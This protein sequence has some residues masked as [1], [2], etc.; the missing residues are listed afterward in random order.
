LLIGSI[1]D[2]A[3]SIVDPPSFRAIGNLTLDLG[4]L[5]ASMPVCSPG[6]LMARC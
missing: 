3:F 2:R 6:E 4:Q 5:E 1:T